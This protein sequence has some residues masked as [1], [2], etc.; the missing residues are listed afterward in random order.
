MRIL[1]GADM[2]N[3]QKKAL[4]GVIG[5]L[6]VIFLLVGAMTDLYSTNV[7]VL[8]A[9]VIWLVG[10]PAL[11]V[12]GFGVEK[13]TG[14]AGAKSSSTGTIVVIV[15]GAV[16]IVALFTFAGLW[17]LISSIDSIDG[18]PSGDVV[19]E[20]RNVSD[21][22]R[23]E[24]R[25]SG[26]LIIDQTGEES[27]EIEADENLIGRIETRVI[28]DTLRI[29]VKDRWLVWPFW[30]SNRIKYHLSV[31]ELE[32]ISISGSGSVKTKSLEA[33]SLGLHISG[34]GEGDLSVDVKRLDVSVSGSGEFILSGKAG[35]QKLTIS[36]S[37]DYDA[38]ELKSKTADITISGSGKGI[39]NATEELDIIISG[40]GDLQY[41]G[42]PSIN[43]RI[44]GSGD[45]SQY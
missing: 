23:V 25:G 26:N 38:K 2:N 21:F 44:S 28:G 17:A 36:G 35:K 32:R 10:L 42:R 39:V 29:R 12:F 37:G 27:L 7:G 13:E 1:Q 9:L 8:I 18:S 16:A 5:G 40:S 33:D 20:S 22:N 6:G 41:L 14:E 3:E 15:I 34:S 11:G 4:R 43:Q 31:D 19:S 45:I 24:L 30:S